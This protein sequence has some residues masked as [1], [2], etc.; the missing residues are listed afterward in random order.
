MRKLL[1]KFC[2]FC[3][4]AIRVAGTLIGIKW[5]GTWCF[6]SLII[7]GWVFVLGLPVGMLLFGQ[8]F[9]LG[10]WA[11]L[12]LLIMLIVNIDDALVQMSNFLT[13][14]VDGVID[15]G[16]VAPYERV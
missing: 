16:E 9:S 8:T 7:A 14:G 2:N 10:V 6:D 12:I 11:T 1:T 15:D 4:G 3:R 13:Y 5:K